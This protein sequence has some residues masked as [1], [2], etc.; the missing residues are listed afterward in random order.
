M[1]LVVLGF[2][3]V[4]LSQGVRFGVRAWHSETRLVNQRAD[5]DGMERVLRDLVSAADAGEANAPANFH[6]D[7]HAVRF[8]SRL[9]MAA[10]AAVPGLPVRDVEVGLGVDARHRLVLRW[11]PHPHA[12]RLTQAPAPVENVLLDG[13]DHIELSY[14]R[15]PE[16]GGGWTS[17]WT[18][19]TLPLTIRI[20]LVFPKDDRR[21]W[22]DIVA[23]PMRSQ[24]TG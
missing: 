24:F 12:E 23:T 22:P 11:T 20:R 15:F 1:A 18:L 9:P 4:G 7:L 3:M 6:G 5:M 14:Q 10:A 19:P 17:D 8:L 16:Q 21:H 13:L 2:L